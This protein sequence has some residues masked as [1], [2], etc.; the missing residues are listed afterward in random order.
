MNA[1][2]RKSKG[3]HYMRK[4]YMMDCNG[5]GT[6]STKTIRCT[7]SPA[8]IDKYDRTKD[9]VTCKFCKTLGR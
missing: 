2:S 4:G 9:K 3:V 1:K 7:G 5:S 6:F 8:T